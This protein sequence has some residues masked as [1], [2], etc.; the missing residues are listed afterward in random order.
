MGF[1]HDSNTSRK[2]HDGKYLMISNVTAECPSVSY[3]V[4]HAQEPLA[5]NLQPLAHVSGASL[6]TSLPCN[7]VRIL[8]QSAASTKAPLSLHFL[9]PA[10]SA[11]KIASHS[12]Q[13]FQPHERFCVTRKRSEELP[14]LHVTASFEDSYHLNDLA[15]FCLFPAGWNSY[16]IDLHINDGDYRRHI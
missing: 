10:I 1:R 3:T 15:L 8:S 4:E 2:A 13:I 6:R 14:R 5:S 7:L 9:V 11:T 12:Q 16:V